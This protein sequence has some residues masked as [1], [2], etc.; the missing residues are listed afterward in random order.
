MVTGAIGAA[1]EFLTAWLP[2]RDFLR[3]TR[4]AFGGDAVMKLGI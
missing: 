2:H 4:R 3:G 1:V